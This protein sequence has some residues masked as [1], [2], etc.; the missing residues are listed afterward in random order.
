MEFTLYTEFPSTLKKDWDALLPDSQLNTPFLRFGYLQHWW[1]TRGGG[2]WPADSQLAIVSAHEGE[3]LIG[4]APLFLYPQTNKN[5]I[6]LLGSKEICDYLD[7]IVR[8][9]HLESFTHGLIDYLSDSRFVA[10]DQLIFYNLLGTSPTISLLEK[11]CVLHH[12]QFRQEFAKQS[13]YILLPGDW[14][15]YLASIDKKQRHEIRRKMRRSA[16]NI[17][18]KW[19]FC[20]EQDTLE[21]DIDSFLQLMAMDVEKKKF[22][23]SSMQQQMRLTL[24]W[25]FEENILQLSFLEILGEKAASYFCFDHNG[26]ILVYNSGY[27]PQFSQ[28]SPGWVLLGNLLQWANENKRS[29]FDFMRGDEEYKYRFGAQDRQVVCAIIQR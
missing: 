25:A 8:P 22:L 14:D 23:T 29:E 18:V 3:S 10:W 26:K 1:Q 24:R 5:T 17:D 2:E 16:Q 27:D 13:P 9:Q 20:R 7:L 11:E 4:I 15:A 28:Y 19:R 6:Y 21:E 12:W